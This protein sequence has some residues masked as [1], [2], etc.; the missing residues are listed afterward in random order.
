MLVANVDVAQA[1]LKFFPPI[2]GDV[3]EDYMCLT[4]PACCRLVGG[5]HSNSAHTPHSPVI[6]HSRKSARELKD[7]H[8]SLSISACD[9][10][11]RQKHILFTLI[12]F[13][14]SIKKYE[15][16]NSTVF[17]SSSLYLCLKIQVTDSQE[18]NFPLFSPLLDMPQMPPSTSNLHDRGWGW[19]IG[20]VFTVTRVTQ[21]TPPRSHPRQTR[22]HAP[23]PNTH[24]QSWSVVIRS[25]RLY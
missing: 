9:C 1:K 18:E 15:K 22:L 3:P 4:W 6:T 17:L 8:H 12:S 5:P 23:P 10:Y 7:I 21:P 20:P 2:I 14:A 25:V 16:K 24:P 19:V 13:L 11:Y